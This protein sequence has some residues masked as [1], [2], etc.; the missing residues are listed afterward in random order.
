[1]A[2]G[3]PDD[4]CATTGDTLLVVEVLTASG[5]ARCQGAKALVKAVVAELADPRIDSREVD[6]IEQ[7]D[8]AV[9]LGVL[10]VPAI[11]IGGEL[12][13][14]AAPSKNQLRRAIQSRLAGASP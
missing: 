8:H 10:R 5:C 2:A 4:A 3:N 13:F 14:S 6:V 7:I 9:K 1:M 11:A 12:V